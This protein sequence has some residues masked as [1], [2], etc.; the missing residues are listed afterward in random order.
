MFYQQLPVRRDEI[1][2]RDTHT[3]LTY[4]E[5]DQK[6][7]ILAT[8][9]KNHHSFAEETPVGVYA[10]RSCESIIAI[11]GI[12]KAGLAYVPFDVDAPVQRTEMILSCLP[13]CQL[14]LLASGLTVPPVSSQGARFA[15]IADAFGQTTKEVKEFL[16][17]APQTHPTSLAYILFTS[18]TTGKP[19]G[20]MVEHK[21]VVRLATDPE[22]AAHTFNF[23]IASHLLN[24]AFDASG[25]EIYAT[26]LNGGTLVCID[27]CVVFDFSALETTFIKQGVKRAFMTP[28]MVKQCLIS[29]PAII[30][31]LDVLYVGGDKLDLA[32]I[33]MAKRFGSVKIFNCYGPT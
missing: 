6:S 24:L 17:K 29:S 2:V 32:D 13:N 26:L 10:N 16:R 18:G 11:L 3:Q 12:L 28:A 14:V 4:S 15:C 7:T 21:G 22:I 23:K 9:L 19:K 27:K 1:A 33:V 31:L 25:F 30:A 5:L 20:V 8:W